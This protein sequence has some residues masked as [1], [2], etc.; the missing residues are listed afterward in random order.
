MHVLLT[1]KG[2]HDIFID[3][4]EGS[5]SNLVWRKT[6]SFSYIHIKLKEIHSI[7]KKSLSFQNN[8]NNNN[9]IIIIK[10]FFVTVES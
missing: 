4:V 1:C 6:L 8:N 10:L 7:P 3:E 2:T 9:K 5:S